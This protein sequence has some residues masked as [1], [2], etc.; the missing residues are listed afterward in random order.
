MSLHASYCTTCG[1]EVCLFSKEDW[2]EFNHGLKS[3]RPKPSTTPQASGRLAPLPR[4]SEPPIWQPIRQVVP[5]R[6]LPRFPGTFFLCFAQRIDRSAA[7]P[8]LKGIYVWQKPCPMHS[9]LPTQKELAPPTHPPRAPMPEIPH[10]SGSLRDARL[11]LVFTPELCEDPLDRL[12]L[13]W[14][15]IHVLQIR[16]KGIGEHSILPTSARETLAW[17]ERILDMAR[18]L[19]PTRPLILINDRVDVAAA[20]LGAGVD[21]VHLGQRD[22]PPK[23]ARERLGPK[24]LIG[25]STHNHR[26]VRQADQEPVDYLGFGAVFPTKTKVGTS[27]NHSVGSWVAAAHSN[28]PVFP[29]GG[30]T[31]ENAWLL[32]PGGRAAVGSGILNHANPSSAA[33]SI[34]RALT[35]PPRQAR[36][37]QRLLP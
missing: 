14:E 21:G 31:P 18:S 2:E 22:T 19:G 15:H 29:I 7:P 5:A 34:A 25:L 10:P 4:G 11:M 6:S 24:A 32:R 8:P 20:L 17:T 35:G 12:A 26:E 13:V 28:I 16:P 27:K 9:S 37:T 1:G 23:V 33:Q 30:I 36:N 3:K